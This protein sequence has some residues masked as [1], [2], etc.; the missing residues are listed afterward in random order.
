[1]F[2][3]KK[4]LSASAIG[5]AIVAFIAMV[6]WL[7]DVLNDRNAKVDVLV[8]INAFENW[9]YHS[10]GKSVF[11]IAPDEE[12]AVLRVRYGKDFM[13]AKVENSK[14]KEGWIFFHSEKAVI[15]WPEKT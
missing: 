12:V 10:P 9:N 4:R 6:L 11:N 3:K 15:Y 8:E 5:I 13:A 14:G 2:K 1:M 7:M